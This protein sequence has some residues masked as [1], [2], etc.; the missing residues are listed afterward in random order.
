MLENK[1]KSKYIRAPGISNMGDG[2]MVNR[3]NLEKN[4]AQFPVLTIHA[5]VDIRKVNKTIAYF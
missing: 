2:A 1:I 3:M 5:D 4:Q